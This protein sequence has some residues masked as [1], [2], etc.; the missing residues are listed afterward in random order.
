[1]LGLVLGV[2]WCRSLRSLEFAACWNEQP[3][4]PAIETFHQY[5]ILSSQGQL[6]F[7]FNETRYSTSSQSARPRGEHLTHYRDVKGSVWPREGYGWSS[8]RIPG[9]DGWDQ[10]KVTLPYWGIVI[11]TL[12]LP[13]LR[14][15]TLIR[16]RQWPIE[17][18]CLCCGYD[19]RATPDRCPECGTASPNSSA[20]VA[21]PS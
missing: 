4:T 15:V 18:C 5:M 6:T 7:V 20:H 17:G 19:L 13:L 3:A 10:D 8:F 21:H 12:L 14:M 2:L 16:D 1:M 9:P 11:A